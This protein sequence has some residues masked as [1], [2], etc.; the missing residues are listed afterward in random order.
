ML[1]NGA[2][3]VNA[4]YQHIPTSTGPG[5]AIIGTG[6]SPGING[7]VGNEWFDRAKNK[8]VYCVEDPDSKDVVTGKQSMSPRNLSVSTIDD[9][10]ELATNGKSITISLAIKDRAS[11]LMAGHAAD[12]V[13]WFD[14]ST[15]TWTTSDFYEKS[16]KLPA[17]VSEVN[18]MKIPDRMRGKKWTL[19]LPQSEYSNVF[20]TTAPSPP[21]GF[22]NQFPHTLADGS[23]FYDLWTFTP[24]G[25][26]FVVESTE[27]AIKKLGI[28][29]DDVPDVITLNFSSNDYLGHRFG[30]YSP[31]VMEMSIA[32]DRSVSR[33]LNF[34]DRN[35]SG[36]LNSVLFVLTADHGVVPVP[37]DLIARK[38][39]GGRTGAEFE[40]NLRKET[41]NA[42]G[43]DCIAAF[44]DGFIWL[45]R[46]KIAEKGITLEAAQNAVGKILSDSPLVFRT[47]ASSSLQNL[48]IGDWYDAAAKRSLHNERGGDLVVI[49]KP[50]V[51]ESEGNGGTGHGTAWIYDQSVP[52][53]FC[54]P[55]ID[56]GRH[57]DNSG[58]Q[59]IAATVCIEL[60]II[61]PSGSVG[62]AIGLT[63]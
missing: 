5:H 39:P 41:A 34:L 53:V 45:D 22:E 13:V 60:G 4:R 58:P 35:V 49:F 38:I 44:S 24:Y 62:R 21:N 29:K 15:G 48:P 56:I 36:G 30:P 1:E 63:K 54:G 18:A 6:S 7:I 11:I 26:D 16:N 33:L 47:Y 19:S 20:P 46:K 3:F 31:E 9:E 17:W 2:N 37:E 52:L 43:V 40:T 28:G 10:L 25:N 23:S 8:M 42:I 50:G 57:L 32:T 61:A 59:D 12:D 14:K 27:H 51:Y 55:G